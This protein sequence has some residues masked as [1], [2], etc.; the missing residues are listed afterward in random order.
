[1]TA[2]TC[3]LN[4]A[5]M[6]WRA[7]SPCSGFLGG[8]RDLGAVTGEE[9]R[10]PL[11]H[12]PG[13]RQNHDVLPLH[14]AHRFLDL[15]HRRDGGG[16]G[17]VRV[18]HDGDP[19]RIEQRILGHRQQLLARGH[20][21]AADPDGR[22]V[23]ILG[24]AGEDAAV[25]QVADVALGDA[26]VAHDEVGAGIVGDDLIEDARQPRA[27]ELEQKLAHRKTGPPRELGSWKTDEGRAPTGGPPLA[28]ARNSGP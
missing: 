22:V 27:V 3:T 19:E 18:E 21:G 13:A 8:D 15:D 5:P 28:N 4:R 10:G 2:S 12:R 23:Q 9:P 7:F 20:V 24:A 25:D 26:A 1:M 16:V 14:V 6:N 11:A 17:A